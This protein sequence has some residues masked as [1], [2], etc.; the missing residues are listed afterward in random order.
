MFRTFTLTLA[1]VLLNSYAF[2]Q[3][4]VWSTD[5]APIIYNHCA[6]CHK[7]GGIAPFALMNYSN[8]FANATSMLADVKSGKMPPWPPDPKYS[9][10]AHERLLSSAEINTIENWVNNGAKEGDPA[11]APPQPIFSNKGD[12]PGTPDLIAKIPAYTSTAS[13][14]DVYQCFVLP[15]GTTV[16]KY[17]TAFEA[18]PG[19][20]GIV[21]HVLVF[22]D[23]TGI[24]RHLDSLTPEPGYVNF[25]GVG[26]NKAI[27][28]GG[29]VPGGAPVQS[30]LGFG[31]RLPK[32]ADIVLQIHYPKGTSG[33]TDSTE[34]H[35]FFSPTSTG[36]RNLSIQPALNYVTNIDS[37][38]FIPANT[39][40]TF[41]EHLVVPPI[42]ISLLGIAPHMHLIGKNI[43]SWGVTPAGDTQRYIR[44]NNWD[45]HWQGFYSFRNLIKV[46]ANSDLYAS[47]Y[48]DN[49]IGNL[50]N[51]SSPPKDVSGGEQTTDEMMLVYFVF[52]PY[53]PG[54]EN[55]KIDS[56]TPVGITPLN[57]YRGF[58]LFDPYPDPANQLLAVKYYSESNTEGMI[59]LVSTDGRV[60]HTIKKGMMQQGYTA[61]Y[62]NVADI[63]TGI[64]ILSVNIAG[65]ML[66]KKVIIKH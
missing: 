51:P 28:L 43:R 5:V 6:S 58:Q 10:L 34:V 27:M 14:N 2:A 31:I 12:L 42:D 62:Y 1:C 19:N 17:I 26:T 37:P 29:W 41:T 55:I 23:T 32:H 63:P 21:H 18:V 16:D 54:D 36:I 38:L 25:G 60:M 50:D 46:P 64:Y 57:Y 39:T 15:S 48:Y 3:S 66:T 33:Q 52:T 9:R 24:C 35:F 40:R 47:A 61:E 56:T 53:M 30:P 8:A 11:L 59:N 44:V 13:T 22:A 65:G 7:S 45:F 49:T 20:R 4:K